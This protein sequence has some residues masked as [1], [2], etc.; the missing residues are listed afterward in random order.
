MNPGNLDTQ[1]GEE[2][3]N[4]LVKINRNRESPL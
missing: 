3:R 2:V 1:T 4:P